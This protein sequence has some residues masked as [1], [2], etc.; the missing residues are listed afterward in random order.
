MAH[1]EYVLSRTWMSHVSR[2]KVL[3]DTYVEAFEGVYV[4]HMN[5][6]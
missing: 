4:A 3:C 6:S 2:V 1:L 5:E